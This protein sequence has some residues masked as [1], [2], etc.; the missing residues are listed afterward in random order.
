M[1]TTYTVAGRLDLDGRR[2]VN[3][4]GRSDV[5]QD[6]DENRLHVHYNQ[7]DEVLPTWSVFAYF[8]QYP[9]LLD[10]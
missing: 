10:A 1:S 2:L 3:A 8:A 4:P 6:A 9:D 7:P 5:F